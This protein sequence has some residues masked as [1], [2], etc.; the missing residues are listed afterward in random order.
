MLSYIVPTSVDTLDFV[1][2][3]VAV[4][5][6]SRCR[7]LRFQ[8]RQDVGSPYVIVVSPHGRVP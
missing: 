7:I 2:A 5:E 3:R 8:S 4:V 1:Y 6:T